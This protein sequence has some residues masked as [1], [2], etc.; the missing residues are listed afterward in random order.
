MARRSMVFAACLVA[1][2]GCQQPPDAVLA[3]H[4]TDPQIEHVDASPALPKALAPAKAVA[5]APLTVPQADPALLNSAVD[6]YLF[7]RR[8]RAAQR[9]N[10]VQE[11]LRQADR[12]SAALDP[13]IIT[14]DLTG[15]HANILSLQFSVEW[16]DSDGYASHVRSIIERYFS[17]AEVADSTCDAGFSRV[18][19]SARGINDH[20][21]HS[22]WTAQFTNEGLL[23][24]SRDG[25][26]SELDNVSIVGG[27]AGKPE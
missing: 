11:R 12:M 23:T 6:C 8:K 20:R 3:S 26:P 18:E 22:I 13:K 25:Q 17:S 9:A 21:I 7:T 24:L 14:V 1:L 2:C 5:S 19:L 10:A 27:L 15:D 16:P 4:R